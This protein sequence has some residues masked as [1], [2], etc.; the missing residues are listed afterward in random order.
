M[1]LPAKLNKKALFL[2]PRSARV[3]SPDWRADGRCK[4]KSKMAKDQKVS[5]PKEAQ[6]MSAILKDMGITDYE[7]GVIN[8]MLEFTYR[9]YRILEYNGVLVELW[10]EGFFGSKN[11]ENLL[12]IGFICVF[13]R[14]KDYRIRFGYFYSCMH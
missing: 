1:N 13:L 6:V 10:V 4:Q 3:G 2:S 14:C 5:M 9:K 11:S 7:P 12:I 8:Q